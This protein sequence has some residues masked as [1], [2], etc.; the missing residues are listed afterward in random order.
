[1]CVRLMASWPALLVLLVPGGGLPALADLPGGAVDG[2]GAD[3][4]DA[5]AA[6][7]PGAD[8]AAPGA[9]LDVALAMA[10]GAPAE[11]AQVQRPGPHGQ[12]ADDGEDV[13]GGH[14]RSP[15]LTATGGPGGEPVLVTGL[16]PN[17]HA[18]VHGRSRAGTVSSLKPLPV[19]AAG[20]PL[21]VLV[22]A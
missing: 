20:E 12:G 6:L 11:R 10:P 2:A 3:P 7:A 13:G 22:A 18:L 17:C 14:G 5:T 16:V 21:A 4:L 15:A 8:R 9:A 1:G 19:D